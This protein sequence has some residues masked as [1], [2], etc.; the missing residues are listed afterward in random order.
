MNF[1]ASRGICFQ[2]KVKSKFILE[3]R[4]RWR[5]FATRVEVDGTQTT[6]TIPPIFVL[7]T[8][9][10]Q[11]PPTILSMD[12]AAAVL[13][14]RS[15]WLCQKLAAGLQSWASSCCGSK[16]CSFEVA[17]QPAWPDTAVGLMLQTVEEKASESEE[18]LCTGGWY[19]R[20]VVPDSAH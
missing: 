18:P 11:L 16:T 3:Q 5:F 8:G 10:S 2:R 9:D 17:V 14:L 6:S 1:G 20:P 12:G 15:S 13:V 7:E 19:S 4:N